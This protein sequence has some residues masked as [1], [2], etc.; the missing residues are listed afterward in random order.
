MNSDGPL[1]GWLRSV[2]LEG[3]NLV[4]T[5]IC[6]W[7]VY[8]IDAAFFQEAYR[9]NSNR[10][11]GT[12][13]PMAGGLGFLI[14]FV[15]LF[16]NFL[17]ADW[18]DLL[19]G[20]FFLDWIGKIIGSLFGAGVCGMIFMPL[21]YLP[22]RFLTWSWLIIKPVINLLTAITLAMFVKK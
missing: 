20:H 16:F 2:G 14:A 1:F 13:F 21:F 3:D 5:L 12:N 11:K 19:T 7:I 15:L 4:S 6:G 17:L 9:K 22:I 10:K 8:G 18:G